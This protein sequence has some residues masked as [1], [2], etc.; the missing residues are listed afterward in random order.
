MSQGFVSL[1]PSLALSLGSTVPPHLPPHGL[2]GGA[3]DLRDTMGWSGDE[4][5]LPIALSKARGDQFLT[6]LV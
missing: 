3:E 1:V 5:L 6:N 2:E 4:D